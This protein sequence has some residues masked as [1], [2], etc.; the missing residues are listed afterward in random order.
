[1]PELIKLSRRILVFRDFKIAGE[2][3]G[4]NETEHTSAEVAAEIGK[5]IAK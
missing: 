2:I 5:Y 4:L 3:D 1:M